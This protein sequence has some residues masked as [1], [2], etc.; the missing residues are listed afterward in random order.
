MVAI[1]LHLFTVAFNMQNA[2]FYFFDTLTSG[3]FGLSLVYWR[4]TALSF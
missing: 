1:L 2:L 4:I 3:S